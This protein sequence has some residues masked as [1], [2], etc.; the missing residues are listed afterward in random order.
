MYTI[1]GAKLYTNRSSQRSQ[2][3]GD[4]TKQH[5]QH[6]FRASFELRWSRISSN[7]IFSPPNITVE[8][9]SLPVDHDRITKGPRTPRSYH[10]REPR[11]SDK[12]EFSF[13][14]CTPP[15]VFLV[16]R[17]GSYR[18]EYSVLFLLLLPFSRFLY[19]GAWILFVLLLSG[20]ICTYICIYICMYLRFQM[21]SL[22]EN[23]ENHRITVMFS[24]LLVNFLSRLVS[25]EW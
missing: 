20:Y 22:N 18:D 3:H 19:L 6:L 11:F 21:E 24:R 13:P 15:F 16:P 23:V 10:D 14:L 7:K 9:P 17:N 1:T 25:Y 2:Q 8:F 4:I 12:S 5:R